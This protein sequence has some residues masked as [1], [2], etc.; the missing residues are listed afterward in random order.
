M[1]IF[2]HI[3]LLIEFEWELLQLK[4]LEKKIKKFEALDENNFF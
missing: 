1:S 2:L 4:L 3:Y